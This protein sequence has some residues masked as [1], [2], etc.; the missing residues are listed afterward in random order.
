M[1]Q[2]VPDYCLDEYE[3]E[4]EE[5]EVNNHEQYYKCI[6][7]YWESMDNCPD[8][9]TIDDVHGG[10]YVSITQVYFNI[11]VFGRSLS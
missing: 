2:E 1:L 5:T 4:D 10:C 9:M 11:L 8:G 7:E 3:D 6:R